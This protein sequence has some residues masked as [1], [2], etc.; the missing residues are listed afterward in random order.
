MLSNGIHHQ[1][2]GFITY[3]YGIFPWKINEILADVLH[4]HQTQLAG[5]SP[6]QREVYSWENIIFK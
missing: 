4:Y 2:R 5:K 6:N 3:V 1:Q